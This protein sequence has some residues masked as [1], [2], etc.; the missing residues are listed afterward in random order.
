MISHSI[1]E[2]QGTCIY[3]ILDFKFL[4][5]QICQ[6]MTNQH[7]NMLFKCL[8][9]YFINNKFALLCSVLFIYEHKK[10]NEIPNIKI[11]FWGHER[12]TFT[13]KIARRNTKCFRNYFLTDLSLIWIFQVTYTY[14][15]ATNTKINWQHTHI[16]R[17]CSSL[18]HILS[19][20]YVVPCIWFCRM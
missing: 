3:K 9:R 20:S 14:D 4:Y 2:T 18:L 7:R 12:V 5:S 10:Y 13:S 16:W 11:T 15:P 17:Y 1:K 6:M 19:N 8:T